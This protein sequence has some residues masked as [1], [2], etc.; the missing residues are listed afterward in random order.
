MI[1]I[2]KEHLISIA[3]LLA[4]CFKEDQ[5]VIK[6]TKGIENPKE[7][8]EKLFLLQLPILQKTCE[9]YALDS[10]L[11]SVIIGYEKKKYKPRK[12]LLLSILCQF[13]L[14]H[15]LKSSDLKFYAKNL[16]DASKSIDLNWQREFIKGNYYYIKVIAIA[17]SSRRKG[18]FRALITPII[19]YCMEK[20]IPIVL[21]TNTPENVPIY[22]HF[23]FELI[24]TIPEKGTDFCQYC[25]IKLP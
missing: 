19:N 15:S 4:D 7:F 12:V 23:G 20:N 24:K 21:E 11:N 16:K 25:F 2:S 17:K 6:Q 9:M 10:N 1:S 14:S 3:K 13:Q 18:V 5:L 22:K 8:L